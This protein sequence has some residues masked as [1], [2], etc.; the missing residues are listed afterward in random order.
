MP[1]LAGIKRR[2]RTAQVKAALAANAELVRNCWVIGTMAIALPR[3]VE[4]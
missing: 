2:V 1:F 4:T 3:P